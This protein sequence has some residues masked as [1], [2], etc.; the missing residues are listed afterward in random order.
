RRLLCLW[1]RDHFAS[2]SLLRCCVGRQPPTPCPRAP[3]RRPRQQP[4]TA[5]PQK[6]ATAGKGTAPCSSVA[7]LAVSQR[8]WDHSRPFPSVINSISKIP[9]KQFTRTS[10]PAR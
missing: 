1:H 6:E 5:C 9:L 2:A 7:T 10:A 3:T 8:H 4:R